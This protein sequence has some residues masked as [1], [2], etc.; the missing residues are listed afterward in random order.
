[1]H[2][3]SWAWLGLLVLLIAFEFYALHSKRRGDTLSENVWSVQ[4]WAKKH[5]LLPL[6]Y[7]IMIGTLGWLILHFALKI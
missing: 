3:Y 5:S 2:W 1:M 7:I 6:F 4:R